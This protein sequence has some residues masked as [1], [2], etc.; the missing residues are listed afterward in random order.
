MNASERGLSGPV[1]ANH[2]PARAIRMEL[3]RKEGQ[4]VHRG[5]CNGREVF[6]VGRGEAEAEGGSQVGW[7]R[8]SG[9]K[10]VPFVVQISVARHY[11]PCKVDLLHCSFIY[12]SKVSVEVFLNRQ[13]VRLVGE[14][15]SEKSRSTRFC[16]L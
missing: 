3:L 4:F 6:T 15:G 7:S 10:I 12:G 9:Y 13:G 8:P 1:S 14:A 2:S 5:C 16:F 11:H